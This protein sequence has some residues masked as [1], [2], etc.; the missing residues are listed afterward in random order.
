MSHFTYAEADLESLNQGDVLRR[1]EEVDKILEEVHPHYYQSE[2]YK[3]FIVLT[4]S[5]DLARRGGELPSTRYIS[6]AAVRPLGLAVRREAESLFKDEFD[7]KLRLLDQ[8]REA[9]LRQFVERLFNNNEPN[10]FYLEK[11]PALGLED[12]YVAFLKLSIALKCEVHYQ[13]LLDAKILQLS[14]SFQHKLG[15]LVGNSYSRIGTEDW[16]PHNIPKKDWSRKVTNCINLVDDL[17]FLPDADYKRVQKKNKKGE[18]A[19]MT[20]KEVLDILLEEKKSEPEVQ[21]QEF[22]K[23]VVDVLAKLPDEE[24]DA[25][26]IANRIVNSPH[27]GTLVKK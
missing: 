3:Y 23:L 27:F 24:I 6:I 9:K 4:Q 16:L 25:E 22:K 26:K 13:T 19:G 1:T 17:N 14:E 15:H 5:C 12:D 18:L 8:K 11:Q 10:L 7:Q 20:T 21:K 2:N